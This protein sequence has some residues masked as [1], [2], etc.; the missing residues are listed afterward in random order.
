MLSFLCGRLWKSTALWPSPR[1]GDL[2][3]GSTRWLFGDFVSIDRQDERSPLSR[4]PDIW[5]HAVPGD[6]L[7]VRNASVDHRSSAALASCYSC[8][9]VADRRE[10]CHSA[11]R[12]TG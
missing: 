3:R 4:G 10:R 5:R 8:Y 1:H 11:P 7:H 6:D 12:A 2:G 9:L